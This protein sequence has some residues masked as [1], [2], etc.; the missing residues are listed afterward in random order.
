LRHLTP[1]KIGGR[2][3][4]S[5]N[6]K[7]RNAPG[8]RQ[9]NTIEIKEEKIMVVQHNMQAMNANRMLGVITSSQSKTTEKLA[10]GYK[11]N[12]AADDAAGLSISEKMRKQIRGLDRAST[13]AQDG[14]SAVQTAEGALTE[15]H[16]MLQRMNELATQA[17]NGTN[18]ETDRQAIQDEIDQLVTEI[19]RV[20]E[21]TKF[22]E[23]YL[24][25]GA[26]EGSTSTQLAAAHDAGLKG[27]LT[28]DGKGTSIFQYGSELKDGSKVTI[29]GKEYT[30]G[31]TPKNDNSFDT[32]ANG[33]LVANSLVNAGD[34]VTIDGETTT[35]VNK[36]SA[37]AATVA[38]SNTLNLKANDTFVDKDGNTWKIANATSE[39]AF[40]VALADLSKY[41]TAGSLITMA[42][43]AATSISVVEE[44]EKGELSTKDLAA[45][46]TAVR[47]N[48]K[49]GDSYTTSGVT[50][51]LYDATA[52]SAA[53]VAATGVESF[54]D[55]SESIK[56]MEIDGTA[57]VTINGTAYTLG[58]K[59]DEAAG[60]YTREDVIAMIQEG[61]RVSMDGGTNT[62]YIYGV[63]DTA[64]ENS[65]TKE[66]AYRMMTEELTK[67][68]SIGTD[69]AASVTHKGN[70]KFEI[71][72]G[73]VEITDP[74]SFNLHVGADAD[75]T[76]KITVDISS[77]SASGLGVK[78]LDVS[79]VTGTSATYAI[80]AI[81]DAISKVSAQRS[82]LGA[83][84]NRLE[85]TIANLDNIVENTTAAESRI[86]DTDMAEMMVEYSK[87]NILAQAGQ[88]MLAQANQATQGVLS[89]LQ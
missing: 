40:E 24:L 85:H 42:N 80:D 6:P 60:V 72:Q 53:G 30:I 43:G 62:Y 84:Q 69:T 81:A 27:T 29:A 67:A 86:R 56:E 68:S 41:L 78:G 46:I 7:K 88:S 20:A 37:S 28:A 49:E 16:S 47:N 45:N 64:D 22:N 73:S 58:T 57:A 65:I 12:R 77:M 15:V 39:A 66:E 87:N 79:D 44:L 36:I 34:S 11:I 23:I 63:S 71:T 5:P 21:T 32:L 13:N 31:S 74:L 89:L 54:H 1:P 18:S 51:T 3:S 52:A 2:S 76:N 33:K 8:Y 26:R 61:D 17:S 35:L 38:A 75:M 48:L 4:L 70:G 25:K 82:A 55:I 50:K 9:Y 10:S 19:D 59:T 14:V 83:V